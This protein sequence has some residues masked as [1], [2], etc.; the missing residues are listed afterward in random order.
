MITT[1]V[2]KRIDEWQAADSG[3]QSELAET[4]LV[5]EIQAAVALSIASAKAM[6]D[7]CERAEAKGTLTE[8]DLIR[9]A[10]AR[11][12]MK[13]LSTVLE[14]CVLKTDQIESEDIGEAPD[15]VN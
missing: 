5:I 3:S 4:L 10:V 6:M 15:H 14:S 7:H 12:E 11:N 13:T 8:D 9:L 2:L 1:E